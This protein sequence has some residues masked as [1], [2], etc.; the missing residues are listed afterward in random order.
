VPKPDGTPVAFLTVT[1]ITARVQAETEARRS[2]EFNNTVLNSVLAQIAVIDREG[3]I[4]AVNDAWSRFSAANISPAGNQPMNTGIGVNYL[5]ICRSAEGPFSEGAADAC[6][7]I[8]SLLEGRAESFTLEYPCPSQE[9]ERWFLLTATPLRSS[10]GG[11]VVSHVDITQ[12]KLAEKTIERQ[13]K[14]LDQANEA[15]LVRD[16]NGTISFWNKG[17]ER[18]YGWT[19]EEAIGRNSIDLLQADRDL[20]EEGAK[21]IRSKGEWNGELRMVSKSGRELIV[22]S[23][24]SLLHSAT[25]GS[26]EGILKIDVD[27]TAKKALETQYLRAQRMESI[28][29]LAGG[30]AH[31]LNN[32]LSPILM[33]IELLKAKLPAA[34]DQALLQML[35]EGATRGADMVRQ[36][37][38]FARG[39]EG[40][41]TLINPKHLMQ[42][43]CRILTETLLKQIQVVIDV[44]ADIWLVRGDPTQLHQVLL[45]LCVN[46]RDAMPHGGTLTLAA[47]NQELDEHYAAMHIEA[48]PGPYM[49]LSVSDTGS[50]IPEHIRERIFEPFFTTK[51]T[52]KGTGLGLA[53]CMAIIKA[54]GGFLNLYSEIGKGTIFKVYLPAEPDGNA[55]H[56]EKHAASLP[57]GNGETILVVDDETSIRE[58]TRQTLEAY[59]F[60]VF[61]ASDGAEAVAVYA[62]HASEIDVVLTDLMMPIMDGVAMIHALRRMNPDIPIIAASGLATEAQNHSALTAGAKYFVPKPYTAEAILRLLHEVLHPVSK[63]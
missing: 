40:R 5:D 19:S 34:N 59:G 35:E 44:P 16:F 55:N 3:R 20:M 30:I 31:D 48:A 33:S 26:G 25:E 49:V 38:T 57:R 41:Q 6:E 37:L 60:N 43:V 23:R 4:I 47:S 42:D 36:I 1:D 2:A 22:E 56:T 24:W 62:Q 17:A 58:I 32:M 15:I 53:T 8:A 51:E 7:G 39:V 12:R 29:T 27:I 14:F 45:N 18:L 63:K 28:G 52:G 61:T 46:A 13:A 10:S 54:H 9:A 11:A 21:Q 50:G